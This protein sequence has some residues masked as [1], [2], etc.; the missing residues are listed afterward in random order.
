[1]S[2]TMPHAK[3]NECHDC[4]TQKVGT[5]R[6]SVSTHAFRLQSGTVPRTAP[7]VEAVCDDDDLFPACSCKIAGRRECCQIF[8]PI[9]DLLLRND[10]LQCRAH[11]PSPV[12]LLS[13]PH[14]FSG[15]LSASGNAQH[16]SRYVLAGVSAC[17]WDGFAAQHHNGFRQ[18]VSDPNRPTICS[19]GKGQLHNPSTVH[20]APARSRTG[21]ISAEQ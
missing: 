5:Y 3:L 16:V 6:R 1:M 17:G 7:L 4:P 15:S 11:R 14:V 10:A 19:G 8:L 20:V 2:L 18:S 9:L 13:L 21:Q 12:G